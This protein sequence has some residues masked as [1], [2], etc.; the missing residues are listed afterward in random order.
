MA[1]KYDVII[2]G[3][4]PAG[5]MAARSAGEEGLNVALL[6][7]KK[8]ISKV[9]RTCGGVI[10]VNEP[11]F[12][13][14]VQYD[15]EKGKFDFT[16]T[17]FSIRYDG[18]SQDVF[19]FHIYSPGGKRLEF[20][21][22]SELRKNARRNRLGMAISKEQLL[23]TLLEESE[24]LGVSIFPNKNVCSVAKNSTE[25]IVECE[26][27]NTF[28]G[29]FVIAADG[30]N[31]RIARVLKLNKDRSFYGTSRD[32]AL[33]IEG[34]NCP[35]PD[36]FL[37]M[38]TPRGIFSMIPLATK[39][40]FQLTASISSKNGNIL[41]LLNY[42]LYED[43]TFSQWYKDSNILQHRTACVVTLMSPI[44]KLFKDNVLFVGD[45]CWRREI[46]N[47]GALCT[48]WK[49]GKSIAEALKTKKTNGEGVKDYLDWY[50]QYYF[51][52]HGTRKQTGRNFLK[53]L[54]PEDIDYLVDLPKQEFQQTMDI[55]KVVNS[56]GSTY[57]DLMSRVYKENPDIMEK[58]ITVR[59]NMEEDMQK[60]VKCGF[61]TV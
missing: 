15:E 51:G 41:D 27:G 46:S 59:E 33:V 53:Y 47:V 16:N 31:S 60:Q 39:N 18:P 5:L 43:P 17:G 21:K 32:I 22:F 9:H 20:G 37:F 48:G 14:I 4:G 3:G 52:P 6:E 10:N 34:T 25:V 23:R 13:E 49:A 30:I 1:T 44:E 8:D 38:F 36:G 29:T 24:K 57:G 19:G 54:A 45:A 58:L 35:D 28:E 56:I 26:D 11:A 61:R 42:F 7:R 50:Q 2:V 55:F 12:G 40:C